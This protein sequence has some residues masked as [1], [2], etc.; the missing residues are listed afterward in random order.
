MS[1]AGLGPCRAGS[2]TSW[3]SDS[4]AQ[5]LG[6]PPCQPRG[7]RAHVRLDGEDAQ[8]ALAQP[9]QHAQHGRRVRAAVVGPEV[10]LHLHAG[11]SP[12]TQPLDSLAGWQQGGR[13]AL[14]GALPRA[15]TGGAWAPGLACGRLA[16]LGPAQ[17]AGSKTSAT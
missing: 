9:A 5:L 15:R 17:L 4:C 12:P 3:A 10:D 1:L 7:A 13:R 8:A 14:A 11:R 6:Y 2:Y 16:E